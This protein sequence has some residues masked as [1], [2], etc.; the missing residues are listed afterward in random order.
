MKK[1]TLLL[2]CMLLCSSLA[3]ADDGRPQKVDHFPPPLP[4]VAKPAEAPARVLN[5]DKEKGLKMWATTFNDYSKDPGFVYFYSKQTYALNKTGIIMDRDKDEFRGYNMWGGCMHDGEY[6]GYVFYLYGTGQMYA[7]AFASVDL[8]KGTWKALR[9]MTSL[10]EDWDVVEAMTNNPKTGKLMGLARNTDGTVT[11]TIGEVDPSTGTY[12]R[13]ATLSQYYFSMDYDLD[14]TLYAVRWKGDSE[15]TLIGSCLVTLDP[16]SN[17]KETVQADLTKNGKPF[18]MN[19]QNSMRFDAA[20]GDLYILA[21]DTE[22]RQ[23]LY[24]I[25]KKTGALETFG[26]IGFGDAATGL[27]IP[28][29]KPDAVDAAARVSDLSSTFDDNGRV[30]LQWTNPTM[31]WDKQDLTELAEVRIYRDGLEK[32]NLVETLPGEDKVGEEMTWTDKTAEAGVHTYYVVPCRRAG[33]K[34]VADSWE[35]FSGRDVPAAPANITIT[36]NSSSSLTVSWEAPEK[37]DHD[38]WYDK[39]GVKYTVT[40]YPDNKVIATDLAET[41]LTDNSLE[42]MESY[43]YTIKG[44]TSDGEGPEGRSEAILAGRAITPPYTTAFETAEEAER[45]TLLDNNRDGNTYSYATYA[46]VGLRLYVNSY[47]DNDDYAIS[48]AIE[49]KGGK[50]Y[51]VKFSVYFN[52]RTEDYEPERVHSFR[53]TAGQGITAEAQTEE[54]YRNDQFQNF[55]Y[56][57]TVPF[58]AFFTP[59]TDGEYNLAF[60]YT[61]K[62]IQ[63]VITVTEFSVEEVFDKDLA[64]KSFEGTIAPVKGAASEYT[65]KV[66]NMGNLAVDDYKVQIVRIDGDK[67]VQLG[68]THVTDKLESQAEAEVKVSAIPDIEG[69]F[70]IA[71]VAVLEGDMNS[72]ND[73]S[74]TLA[75]EAAP[76]GTK[77]F[78]LLLTGDHRDLDTR[79]PMSFVKYYSQGESIYRSDEMGLTGETKIYRMALEYDTNAPVESFDVQVYLGLTDEASYD[80]TLNWKP[81]SSLTKVYDGQQSVLSGNDNMM[82]FNFTEPFD[83]DPSKNLVVSVRKV[84]SSPD[85]DYPAMFHQYDYNYTEMDPIYRSLRFENN[86]DSYEATTGDGTRLAN[87]PVLHLAVETATGISEVVVGYEGIKMNGS[88]V[89]LNGID[90]SEIYV[91]DLTGRAVFSQHLAQGTSSVKTQLTQGVYVVKA[92]DRNGKV[93][94]RKVQG[95][96]K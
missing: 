15:G 33:E 12:T 37:G 42:G 86:G 11:S 80:N 43:Y 1:S 30:I 21:N 22:M 57:E 81:L 39:A 19:Y 59:E 72:S 18:K 31:T 36:Q 90:A 23:Y 29:F 4:Q 46:P 93:Y 54:L 95:G 94:T 71:A 87:L 38:G 61:S 45:W 74:Q 51:R 10:K 7:H 3:N 44:I 77:P 73:I 82:V 52:S 2:G 70:D 17:Y 6:L 68:E 62:F 92:V 56:Y 83:Y 13:T 50:K 55:Q 47:A 26:G 48:P 64:A 79:I 49:M 69:K 16:A 8:E 85:S 65:V 20:T 67:K 53:I 14:G 35:A 91:Y 60:D 5:G 75:V 96:V 28:S 25:D 88:T 66:A 9:D 41:T 78:N 32:S 58:E 24:R 27:Y 63:D 84:G 76:E 40:R 89:D 34:G